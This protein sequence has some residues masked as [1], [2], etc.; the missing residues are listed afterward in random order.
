MDG[1]QASAQVGDE[2]GDV[3][4]IGSL[5]GDE[6]PAILGMW[7]PLDDHGQIGLDVLVSRDLPGD[8]TVELGHRGDA[9]VIEGAVNG[10]VEIVAGFEAAE[11]LDDDGV[12]NHDRGVRLLTAK[13]LG[14][15]NRFRCL[16]A[17]MELP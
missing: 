17:A 13:A 2:I 16:Q 8:V 5:V 3:L 7:K 9:G 4:Q 1:S 15:P 12:A 6:F 14:G 11:H 10:D